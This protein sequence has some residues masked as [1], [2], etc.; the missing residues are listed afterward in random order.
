MCVCVH[1]CVRVSA[2][3]LDYADSWTQHIKA[4]YLS[5]FKACM[6]FV[7]VSVYKLACDMYLRFALTLI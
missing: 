2:L 6:L 4:M 7:A 5:S 1:T 3:G